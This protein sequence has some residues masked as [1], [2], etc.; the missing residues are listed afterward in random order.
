VSA[1]I[2]TNLDDVVAGKAREIASRE[3]RS[4]SNLVANAVAVFTD[5]PKG[6]RDTLLELRAANDREPLRKLVSDME[7]AAAKAQFDLA[8]A[9]LVASGDL[10][11]E[12]EGMSELE[13]MESSTELVKSVIRDGR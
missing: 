11:P 8:V 4:I 9:R 13:L 7:R 3:H 5:L 6:L 2:S 12:S 10:F 1:T